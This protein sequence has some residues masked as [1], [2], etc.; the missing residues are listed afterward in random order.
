MTF[1]EFLDSS[2]FDESVTYILIVDKDGIIKNGGMACELIDRYKSS[3]IYQVSIYYPSVAIF[4]LKEQDN[5]D[6]S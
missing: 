6:N 4:Y 5:N 2:V 3:E 1:E